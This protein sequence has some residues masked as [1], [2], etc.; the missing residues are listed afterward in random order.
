VDGRGKGRVEYLAATTGD[1][2]HVHGSGPRLMPK[3]I[4]WIAVPDKVKDKAVHVIMKTNQTGKPGDGKIFVR[5]L[6][7]AVRIRTADRGDH[8]LDEQT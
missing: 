2:A 4:L 8:A 5:P 7:D 6:L 1:L 3:R